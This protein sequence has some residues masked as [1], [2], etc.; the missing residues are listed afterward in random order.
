MTLPYVPQYKITID[1]QPLTPALL[2]AVSSI[3]YQDAIEG[4]DRVEVTF[5]NQNLKL[6]DDLQLQVDNGF[7]LSIGYAPDT[8]EE[9]FVGEITG[10]EPTFPNSGMPTIKV[11]AHDFLQR[12]TRGKA[13]R[14][15]YLNTT[16]INNFPIPDA[17]VVSLVSATN[18]LIPFPDPFGGALSF[19]AGLAIYLSDPAEA[20][21]SI[22]VQQGSSD[23]E[24]LSTIS[25]A[26][27][28]EMAIDH[29][30][31][32]HG[33]I[34]RFRSL[35]QD[36]TSDFTLTYGKSLMEFSPRI[37]TVGDVSGVAARIWVEAIKT[38]FEIVVGW[39]FDRSVFTLKVSPG[40]GSLEGV[41]SPEDAAEKPSKPKKTL[42]KTVSFAQAGLKIL[43][44]LLPRLNNRVTASGSTV[45]DPRIKSG[46]VIDV[47]GVGDEFGGTWR[48]TSATHT[49][50]NAGYKTNFEARKEV[51]FG[52][53]PKPKSL[54][55]TFSIQ[56]QR[57]G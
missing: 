11:V 29:T 16:S 17:I 18:L 34:L 57:L 1:G 37:T 4:A 47:E 45:G 12:L 55:G 6:L 32:P 2:A 27:G 25:K 8:L 41:P 50:G 21:K 9:V 51:W 31:E 26:N 36:Y 56:G 40:I 23:F 52:S 22:R 30:K 7:K 19:L 54:A 43:A 48:I 20:Q 5:A 28:W 44:D 46:T 10:V 49:F 3:N 24:F 33:Y 14:A 35:F 53:L 39:D 15:F 38:E 13:D 42:S